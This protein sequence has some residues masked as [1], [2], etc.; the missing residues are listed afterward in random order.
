MHQGLFCFCGEDTKLL[1]YYLT[2]PLLLS[3]SLLGIKLPWEWDK[4]GVEKYYIFFSFLF[5][6]PR[7]ICVGCQKEEWEKRACMCV[8]I[9]PA[10]Q[11]RTVKHIWLVLEPVIQ[12]RLRRFPVLCVTCSTPP[13]ISALVYLH[14][15]PSAYPNP[16]PLLFSLF[17]VYSFPPTHFYFLHPL[18]SPIIICLSAFLTLHLFLLFRFTPWI[19]LS[20]SS[21]HLLLIHYFCLFLF[22]LSP[23]IHSLG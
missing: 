18:V 23:C 13:T 16:L 15:W 1:C 19:H 3:S 14:T 11:G 12:W 2:I 5:K 17:V 6:I 8:C 20:F 9:V 7:Q 4:E 10:E 22:F 21:F